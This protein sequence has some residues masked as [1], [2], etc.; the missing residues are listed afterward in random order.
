[1]CHLQNRFSRRHYRYGRL[2]NSWRGSSHCFKRRNGPKRKS[3]LTPEERDKYSNLILLCQKDH[4]IIDD[5]EDVYPVEKLLEIKQQHLDWVKA[6]LNIDITKQKD[7][8]TYATYIE[9]V[10]KLAGIET[11]NIWTSHLLSGGKPQ[12]TKEQFDNLYKLN[13]YLLARIWPKR[14]PNLEF[15]FTNFRLIL[16][17]FLR[18][19]SRVH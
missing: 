19:L 8:E 10:I 18:V 12:I 5:H 7:D 1:M 6:H 17:D 4:K 3:D 9:D 16:N 2:L 14:Y 11:W 15:G 13:E